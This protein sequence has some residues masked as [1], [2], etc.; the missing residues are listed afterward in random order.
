[1]EKK[2]GS[3][4]TFML[5]V[6]LCNAAM[7]KSSPSFA[8]I[9]MYSQRASASHSEQAIMVGI[10]VSKVQKGKNFLATRRGSCIRAFELFHRI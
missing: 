10:D 7:T 1:M 9:L 3:D 8:H 4:A 6:I 5:F 2:S